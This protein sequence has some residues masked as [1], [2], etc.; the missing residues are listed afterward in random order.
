MALKHVSRIR[1]LPTWA[2]TTGNHVEIVDGAATVKAFSNAQSGYRPDVGLNARN[3]RSAGIVMLLC[4]EYGLRH[5]NGAAFFI[6]AR[7]LGK[8]WASQVSR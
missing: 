8:T 6:A 7:R 5:A 1:S 2:R 3:T 4:S